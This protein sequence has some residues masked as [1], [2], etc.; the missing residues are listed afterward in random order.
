MNQA[1]SDSSANAT[2]K[3][4]LMALTIAAVGVVFGDIGTSP[5]YA[6]KECFSPHYGLPH[7]EMEIKGILSLIFWSLTLIIGVKY[8]AIIMRFGNNG[9]GGILALMELVTK[10]KSK[11]IKR[12]AIV[13]MG[14][15]GSA[16]L[17]GDGVITPA[18]SVLSAIEG[19]TVAAPSND[20]GYRTS[21]PTANQLSAYGYTYGVLIDSID[22]K[23]KMAENEMHKGMLIVKVNGKDIYAP[24]SITRIISSN[25][26]DDLTFTVIN[27]SGE[28][29]TKIID[30]PNSN[31]FI[32]PITLVILFGLFFIQKYGTASVGKIFGPF[33]MGWFGLLAILG[34]VSISKTPDI[35]WAMN[36]YH[37]LTF[38][39]HHGFLGFAVLGSVFLV[40]TGGEALY[41][42]MGH[43][44]RTP[45]M[46]GWFYFAYPALLLQYF[47]QGALL[48]REGS[49]PATLANPFFHMVPSW[50]VLPLVIISTGAT[51][52]ASQAVISGS[53]SLTWQALQLGYLPRLKVMHTSSE[54]RGQI[55]IPTINWLLFI[56]CVVLVVTFASSGALA[57]AYGIAVTSTMVITTILAW[58]AMRN[59]LGWS[60]L[61]ATSVS[62]VFL[63][64][65]V[66]FVSAN[67]LKFF[68]GGYVPIVL[69]CIVFMAMVT[70]HTGRRL[71][72][73]AIERTSKPLADVLNEPNRWHEH[74]AG[75][76]I[77]MTQTI[78]NA[79]RALV[80]NLTYNRVRHEC[81]VFLSVE[82]TANAR[83]RGVGDPRARYDVKEIKGHTNIYTVNVRYGFMDQLDIM[84]DL[85]FLPE[86]DVMVDVTDAIFVL[87]HE[88]ISIR[89]GKNMAKW[90]KEIFVFL[91][92]NSR[93]P[94]SY[95]GIPT[96]RTLEL[97][98][99]I[100]I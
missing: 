30:T 69:A 6:L 59:I 15:F 77:Y 18:I 17:Y 63:V 94:A 78:G 24:D 22:P 64:I 82:I 44:G 98:A 76:A 72:Q 53:F 12:T 73:Q 62:M 92:R 97:G 83:E 87:G 33:M 81:L 100:G 57:A 23:G 41:A 60:Q 31:R 96:K 75:T 1:H 39:V 13:V 34:I 45:I 32:V 27:R 51:I 19:L 37:A 55:Y 93:T 86:L 36:P 11:L 21:V 88:T 49:N 10:F 84:A 95:F 65:D 25:S 42:D 46:R 68:H 66:A 91:H 99:H 61:A 47:G 71:L 89:D 14:L 9:E 35:L 20:L 74:V 79:P 26:G 70:W 54:E 56:L 40:V 7:S 52:I 48:L 90:R 38:F 67:G 28:E 4:R 8:L 2:S 85:K 50:G 43:F 80:S 29:E 58:L 3:S 16:L 5:L